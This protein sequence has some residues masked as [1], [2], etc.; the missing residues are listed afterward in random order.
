MTYH[1]TEDNKFELLKHY[2]ECITALLPTK[3]QVKFIKDNS[4]KIMDDPYYQFLLNDIME[5]YDISETFYSE[6]QRKLAEM[7]DWENDY[8]L[9]GMIKV[10]GGH[11]QKIANDLTKKASFD[12][13]FHTDFSFARGEIDDDEKTLYLDI[14]EE[15]NML[16]LYVSEDLKYALMAQERIIEYKTRYYDDQICKYT[17]IFD[18]SNVP[19][20][21]EI[22]I[23]YKE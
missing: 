16:E 5:S 11:L 10:I 7:D 22:K 4:K 2:I 23:I 15:E 18:I 3:E 9:V 8:E 12:L 21:T 1:D 19:A 6:V 13:S 20:E 14:N 17:Y